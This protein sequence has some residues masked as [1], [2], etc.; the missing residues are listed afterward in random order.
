MG[1]NKSAASPYKGIPKLIRASSNNSSWIDAVNITG[2]GLLTSI[3]QYAPS[4]TG[5]CKFIIDGVE[6]IFTAILSNNGHGM[7]IPLNFEFKESLI[8]QHHNSTTDSTVTTYVSYIL[9]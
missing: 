9:Q 4:G 8:V 5:N 7:S 6:M 1:L 3:S 2:S